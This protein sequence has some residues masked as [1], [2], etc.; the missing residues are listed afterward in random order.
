MPIASS[1]LTRR[2]ARQASV[3]LC[4]PNERNASSTE[5]FACRPWRLRSGMQDYT[6]AIESIQLSVRVISAGHRIGGVGTSGRGSRRFGPL[7]GAWVSSQLGCSIKWRLSISNRA[8]RRRT[9]VCR[10][11]ACASTQIYAAL[12]LQT[13]LKGQGVRRP[14]QILSLATQARPGGHL[15]SDLPGLRSGAKSERRGSE[16]ATGTS[17]K[18]RLAPTKIPHFSTDHR[19]FIPPRYSCQ[20]LRAVVH[21]PEK[22]LNLHLAVDSEP[23]GKI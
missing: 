15:S 12:S 5:V 20:P 14:R 11:V 18:N 2:C 1:G 3:S 23:A 13:Q 22:S 8:S 10:P 4:L 16:R 21:R 7:R 9:K 19:L 6:R 17:W